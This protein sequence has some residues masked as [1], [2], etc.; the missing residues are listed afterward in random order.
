[1]LLGNTDPLVLGRYTLSFVVPRAVSSL[2]SDSDPEKRAGSF[3]TQTST[4]SQQRKYTN[5][6]TDSEMVRKRVQVAKKEKKPNVNWPE[7]LR[8]F[9]N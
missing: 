9:K 1:M 6:T 4:G 2:S 3:I 8:S 5:F 7:L